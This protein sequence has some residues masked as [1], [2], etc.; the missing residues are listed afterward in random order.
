MPTKVDNC[1]LQADMLYRAAKECHHQHTRYSRLVER[2]APD[3]EQRSALEMAYMCDDVLGTAVLGYEKA[4]GKN[5]SRSEDAWW[6]KGNMLWHAS[7]EYIRRHASCDGMA[8]RLGKQSPN[9][10][11]ELAMEFDLEASALL[12]LRMAADAYRAA[13]PEAE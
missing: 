10:L 7:R 5:A 9:R 8:K 4:S 11:A 3:E 12:N 2:G 6:H 1:Q 13:R